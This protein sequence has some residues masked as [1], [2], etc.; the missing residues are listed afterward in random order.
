MRNRKIQI[1]IVIVLI[2]IAA[3]FLGYRVHKNDNATKELALIAELRAVR[4]GAELYFTLNSTLPPDLKT[5][6]TQQYTIGQKQGYYLTGIR[7]DKENYPIDSFGNKIDYDPK[8]GNIW[9]ITPGYEG[10]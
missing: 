4:T 6:T 9:S 8:T 5:L 3:A 2:A 1:A 10:W 7:V